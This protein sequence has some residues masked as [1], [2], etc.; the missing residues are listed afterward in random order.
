MNYIVFRQF[1]AP[2]AHPVLIVMIGTN[3]IAVTTNDAAI[4][5][6]LWTWLKKSK[7][8]TSSFWSRALHFLHFKL[9]IGGFMS[10][11]LALSFWLPWFSSSFAAFVPSFAV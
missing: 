10:L 8:E 6:T 11:S 2:T 9:A 4:G 3:C 5:V 1:W 7:F